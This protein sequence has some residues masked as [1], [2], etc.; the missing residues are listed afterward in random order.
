MNTKKVIIIIILLALGAGLLMY[1]YG[2]RMAAPPASQNEAPID[3]AAQQAAQKADADAWDAAI[4]KTQS[5]DKDFDGLTDADEAKYGTNPG[6]YDTDKDGL[7]DGAEV[8]MFKTNPLK[9]DTDGDGKSDGIE[10]LYNT[11]PNKK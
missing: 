10:A 8:N 1:I 3:Q 11:D 6:L 7:S 5:V 2:R 9:A 4:K